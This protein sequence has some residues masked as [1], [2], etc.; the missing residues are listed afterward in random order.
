MVHDQNSAMLKDPSKIPNIPKPGDLDVTLALNSPSICIQINQPT[1]KRYI[2]AL[3]FPL[4]SL[5]DSF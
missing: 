4:K 3:T 1:M 2:M 5:A